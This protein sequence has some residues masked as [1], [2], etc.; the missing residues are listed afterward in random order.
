MN[1]EVHLSFKSYDSFFP[2]QD[3][4][5]D[6]GFGNLV[7]L[8]LQGQARRKGNS[9]FVDENYQPYPDQWTFLLGIHSSL[10]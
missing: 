9:V 4:L 3:T 1:K 5:P 2:N 6:G 8:P 10:A 7:A